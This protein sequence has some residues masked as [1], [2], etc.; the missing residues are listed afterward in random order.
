MHERINS[1]KR[2]VHDR[3]HAY[4]AF[5]PDDLPG[6]GR[7]L[8]TLSSIIQSRTSSEAISST[9]LPADTTSRCMTIETFPGGPPPSFKIWAVPQVYGTTAIR[10]FFIDQTGVFRGGDKNGGEANQN[11]PPI[12]E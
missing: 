8:R 12:N 10:S 5:R 9:T 2:A 6:D 11:D 3:R 1:Q 4:S 7:T